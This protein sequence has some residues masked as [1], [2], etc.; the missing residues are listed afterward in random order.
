M[1]ILITGASRGIGASAYALLKDRGH[2]VVGHSSKGSDALIAGDLTDPAAPR[3]IWD[4][5]LDELDGQID[6]LVN[7]AGIY[8]AVAD[9]ATDE[10]WHQAWQRTLT[11]NLQ[12]AADLSK[13]AVSHFL[14][15]GIPGR[16]V[17]VAS[18]AAFRGDSPQHWHYAAS[19][20][21]LVGMT[22]TIARGYAQDGVLCFA[23][24]PG[25][26]VSEMTEEYL[27]GRGGAKIVADIPLGRVAST[28]EIAEV[29]RWLAIDAPASATG[30]VIDANGAS[31]VR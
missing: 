4:T 23:V 3:A 27:A 26:T 29:I 5:A 8:E 28:D 24:A 13:L 9:N 15:L 19:K 20:A 17:N 30:S 21:A 2:N 18:R 14:D 1:N 6:V 31:Y 10:E 11:V 16:I 22:R 25:F 7:N 12:A